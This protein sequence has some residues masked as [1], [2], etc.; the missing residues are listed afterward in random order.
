VKK[1][2]LLALLL[3]LILFVSGCKDSG[4]EASSSGSSSS[5]QNYSNEEESQLNSPSDV[6][7]NGIAENKTVYVRDF[8]AFPNDG[9]DDTEAINAAI[10][11]ALKNNITYVELEKGQYD[12]KHGNSKTI[13]GH[14][15]YLHIYNAKNL[16]LK[17]A[18]DSKGTLATILVRENPCIVDSQQ[19]PQAMD[20]PSIIVA[21][22]SKNIKIENLKLDNHPYFYSAGKVIEKTDEKI[23][24]EILKGHPVVD[25]MAS[26]I[27]G[28][29][30]LVKKKLKCSRLTFYGEAKWRVIDYDKRI[31]ELI[32]NDLRDGYQINDINQNVKVGDG[33]YWFFIAASHIP[34]I[35]LL[36]SDNVS[37]NNI[38]TVNA[39]GF[40]YS[41]IAVKDLTINK[42][43]LKPEG[44]RIATAPRDG[45]KINSCTGNITINDLILDGCND[46]GIN[47]HSIP[48]EV[49]SRVNDTT[50]ALKISSDHTWLMKY[51][52]Q[53]GAQAGDRVTFIDKQSGKVIC[54]ASIKEYKYI[55]VTNLVTLIFDKKLPSEIDSG[56]FATIH[57][58][59]TSNFK[60]TNSAFRNISGNGI[61]FANSKGHV[62]NTVFEHING[63]G[64]IVGVAFFPPYYNTFEMT[65]PDSL[66]IEKCL[67]RDS[68][69]RN[70]WHTG[71]PKGMVTVCN[72][73]RLTEKS[74]ENVI[75]RDSVFEDVSKG[76]SCIYI[77][78]L[79]KGEIYNNKY[80]AD[81]TFVSFAD[82]NQQDS[83]TIGQNIK[84]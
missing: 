4:S 17:G 14:N 12:L 2:R 63:K 69:K 61:V 52:S 64:I 35:N 34:Q 13:D 73:T 75:V 3:L 68:D 10:D 83:V 67:F 44:N 65:I 30:D 15:G 62:E 76:S 19:L 5:V 84:Q 78:N 21:Y 47:I 31:M 77:N 38:L 23:R 9:K 32:I 74:I 70:E 8:G 16:T 79:I 50:V 49:F 33:L 71:Q 40:A 22:K 26:D 29:Y 54:N 55:D 59:V 53:R 28:S 6:T 81:A 41:A 24:V 11:Y 48:F 36:L 45:F 57:S 42:V 46:D 66:V 43:Y 56:I 37:L 58:F 7:S 80:P 72:G 20:L 1:Q 18:V 82:T 27:M 51:F 25:G 60:V 39:S